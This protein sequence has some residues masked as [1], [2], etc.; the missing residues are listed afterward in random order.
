MMRLLPPASR[1]SQAGGVIWAYA[2][3]NVQM[4]VANPL[5]IYLRAMWVS[6]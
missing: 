3:L 2:A 5:D 1:L 4:V 6:L